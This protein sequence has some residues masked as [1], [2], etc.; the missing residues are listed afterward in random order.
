MSETAVSE[1]ST[2]PD[3]ALVPF[4]VGC[5][6][7]GE[8]LRGRTE[9]VCP[10]CG[11]AFDWADAVPV[12]HLT[13]HSCGY[14]L[15]GLTQPRCPECGKGFSWEAVLDDYRR[16]QK[17]L[18]EYRWREEPLRSLVRTWWLAC[19][20]WKLWRMVELHDPPKVGPLIALLVIGLVLSVAVPL[21]VAY[22]GE[23]LVEYVNSKAVPPWKVRMLVQLNVPPTGFPKAISLGIPLRTCVW[24]ADGDRLATLSMWIGAGFLTLL[25]LRQSMQ[26]CRVRTVHVLRVIV[27]SVFPWCAFALLYSA[28]LI[29]GIAL[30]ATLGTGL[31]YVAMGRVL[32]EMWLAPLWMILAVGLGYQYY[33][34]MAHAWWVAIVAQ[35]IAVMLVIAI[36]PNLYTYWFPGW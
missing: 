29:L 25:V 8:D 16:R 3:W 2:A 32:H 9:P 27:L 34:R 4:A 5:A 26:R 35:T 11:L 7:C 12:E 21:G 33:I 31:Y 22:G 13:C 15:M 30:E 18:F 1:Q 19:R 14:H 6:R 20:P 28:A 23:A 24:W 17:P 10:A 36:W